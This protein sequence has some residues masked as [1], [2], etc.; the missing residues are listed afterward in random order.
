MDLGIRGRVAIIT[1]ASHGLGLA[2]AKALAAE[3]CHLVVAAR[4]EE[5]LEAAAKQ[6]RDAFGVKVLSVATDVTDETQVKSMVAQT[7][8]TFGRVD[9]CLANSGGPPARLISETTRLDW[10][11]AFEANLLSVVTLA[12]TTLPHMKERGWGR[13]L[14]ISS[15]VAKQPMERMIL[16]NGIRPGVGGLIKTLSTEHAASNVTVNNLCPGFFATQ[17]LTKLQDSAA[18]ASDLGSPLQTIPAGRIG[19]PEEFGATMAFLCS[20]QAAYITGISLVIDGGY[21]KSW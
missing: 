15:V 2:C 16:S 3:G 8:D 6:L 4:N 13:F 10:I 12:Q 21:H 14:A 20:E 18:T 19:K 7:T 11:E 5:K 1:G 17:R 9:I